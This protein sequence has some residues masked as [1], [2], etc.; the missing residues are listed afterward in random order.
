MSSEEIK[1]NAQRAENDGTSWRQDVSV[2]D[3]VRWYIFRYKTLPARIK[4][5]FCK[6]SADSSFEIFSPY[7]RIKK[8]DADSGKVDFVERPAVPGYIFVRSTLETAAELSK[9]VDL[10]LWKKPVS[11]IPADCRPG[12]PRPKKALSHCRSTRNSS[13]REPKSA[14]LQK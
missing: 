10:P 12:K 6:C 14:R 3:F 13:E 7:R 11:G 9:S 2:D 5:K 1:T 8:I 4:D